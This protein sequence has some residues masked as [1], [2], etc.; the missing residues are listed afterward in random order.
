MPEEIIYQDQTVTITN[1]KIISEQGEYFLVEFFALDIK[2]LKDQASMYRAFWRTVR[3]ILPV[4]L[5][6]LV[7]TAFIDCRI[8]GF[9]MFVIGGFIIW[10][11]FD[12]EKTWPYVIYADTRRGTKLIFKGYGKRHTENL[13]RT[14]AEVSGCV[15]APKKIIY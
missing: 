1:R 9:M 15:P 13:A 12:P 14:I 2:Q 3:Y 4:F 6:Y 8:A 11:Y 5:I 7:S 10:R